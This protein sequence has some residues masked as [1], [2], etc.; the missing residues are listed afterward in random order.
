[1]R[2]HVAASVLLHS[3]AGLHRTPGEPRSS[4]LM[5][6]FSHVAPVSLLCLLLS[7]CSTPPGPPR[8]EDL[9]MYGQPTL[10]RPTQLKQA[11]E[12]FIATA[13][14]G[15]GGNGKLASLSWIGE[16]DRFF[17]AGNLNVAMRRYNQA[18]LLDDTNYEVYSGFARVLIAQGKFA[19]AQP[20]LRKAIELCTDPAARDALIAELERISA[21]IR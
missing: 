2:R 16:A 21:V 19:E 10:P 7:A 3:P 1:M 4:G 13:T 17:E 9:P 5:S 11:D 15:F 20:H 8:V 14:A 6:F 12:Q 18:W